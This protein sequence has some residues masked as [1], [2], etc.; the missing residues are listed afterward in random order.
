MMTRC[1]ACEDTGWVCE[2]HPDRPSE[3][4]NACQCGGA[5]KP[6]RCNQLRKASGPDSR[7]ASL[8]KSTATRAVSTKPA[9][10]S[11]DSGPMVAVIGS[12]SIDVY[13]DATASEPHGT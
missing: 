5:G 13:G 2:N 3:G 1:A 12:P 10:A 7:P 6:C 4:P 9:H 11:A 8:L